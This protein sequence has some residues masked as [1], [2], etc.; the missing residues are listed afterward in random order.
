LTISFLS[1][2]NTAKKDIPCGLEIQKLDVCIFN[3]DGSNLFIGYGK[4][5]LVINLPEY[6]YESKPLLAIDSDNPENVIMDLQFYTPSILAL[7]IQDIHYGHIEYWDLIGRKK[8]DSSSVVKEYRIFSFCFSPNK[9]EIAIVGKGFNAPQCLKMGV[10][11]NVL[12]H[13]VYPLWVRLKQIQDDLALPHDIIRH[14]INLF[15]NP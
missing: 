12:I 3:P 11:L 9:K 7:L 10:P 6:T 2:D 13:S 14:C 8:I 15:I 1:I 5:I 4:K